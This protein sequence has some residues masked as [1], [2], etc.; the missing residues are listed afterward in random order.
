MQKI[1]YELDPQ[2]RL[3]LKSGQKSGLRKFRK[4]LDG[5]FRT[6]DN[7]EL[8][9]RIKTPLLKNERVPNQLILRGKWS[10]TDNHDLRLTLDKE[11]RETFGDKI[12]LQGRILDVSANS[13]L[14]AVTTKT[15]ENTR[16]TYALNLGGIWKADES[17]R[18]SFHVKREKDRRD[19][20][21]FKGAWEINKNH[22]IIYNYEKADLIR[23][24]R[25]THTL[26]FKG[27]WDIKDSFRISYILSKDTDSVFNLRTSAAIFKENY[28]KY[29]LGIGLIDREKPVKRALTLFGK[30]KIKKNAGLI[31]EVE[32]ENKKVY[33]IVFGA[34]ARL[35][36]K[37]TILFKLK[38]DVENRNIGINVKLSRKILK[39]GG[40][41][42]VRALKSKR[43]SAV[44]AGAAWK[45]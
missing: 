7:N 40:E 17:N 41:A 45:W 9:Y 19:I 3:I 38:N 5:R 23:K 34:E 12:T 31:F 43:E 42:F 11:G 32:Y 37:D 18:L 13:L 30:W 16:S 1:R 2:N 21:T 24:K 6:D 44:Y 22:R 36:G 26:T 15:K 33:E 39:G 27:Y 20:L 10:L 35:T 8:S 14:F 25:K 29:K 28:I 4:V